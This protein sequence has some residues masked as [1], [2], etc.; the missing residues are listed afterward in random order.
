MDHLLASCSM[1][2][3]SGDCL[4]K[5]AHLPSGLVG[6]T[7]QDLGCEV[8]SKGY[9]LAGH[10]GVAMLVACGAKRRPIEQR[11]QVER[12]QCIEDDDFVGSISVDGLV[13][14]E[15]GRG[16]VAGEV[17]GRRRSWKRVR[18]AGNKLLEVPLALGSSN[19]RSRAIVV[20]E[21]L[22]GVSLLHYIQ[23]RKDACQII[24]VL[25]VQKVLLAKE[26]TEGR[27]S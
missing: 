18:E 26:F 9:K 1:V 25:I 15:V 6:G 13:Q 3:Q 17:K 20:V 23:F 2:P 27:V 21:R 8:G 22:N 10:E 12:S 7:F 4:H 24:V 5:K 16:I 14:R 11:R 19:R